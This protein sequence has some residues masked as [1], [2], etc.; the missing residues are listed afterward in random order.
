MS[1]TKFRDG[2]ALE[3][4]YGTSTITTAGSSAY[5]FGVVSQ[6]AVHPSPRTTIGYRA[7]GVGA[8]EV[9]AGEHWKQF[10]D[11]Q[12]MYAVGLQNGIPIWAALGSSSTGAGPP[13]T[14]TITAGT[15]LPSFTIYHERTGTATDWVT[16]FTGCKVAG[17]TLSCSEEQKY[18]IGRMDWIA[19][20]AVDPNL[21]G[22]NATLT[23]DPAL[24]ATATTAPYKF[25]GMTRTYNAVSIDGL[26]GME[27]Q[28]IPDLTPIRAHKWDSGTYTGQ[29]LYD[30]LEDARRKYKLVLQVTPD[31]DD[32]WDSGVA[33]TLT[34]DF[35]FKWTK[36]TDDYIEITCTD[37][38]I[39]YPEL[40]TPEVGDSLVD[41]YECEPR[42][43]TVSVKDAIAGSAYGE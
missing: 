32:L 39:T 21:D 7:T 15:S 9:P 5:L 10:F 19:Q 23:N 6:K 41:V 24:P 43:V 40:Q 20:K 8:A 2:Y 31:S 11:L 3:T 17:L 28:I 34:D 35:V 13:Y 36:S 14:H 1:Y 38:P 33:Q 42:S 27:L 22:T 12:G 37:C 30:L 16:L 25:S 29:W 26:V 18:L 4:I